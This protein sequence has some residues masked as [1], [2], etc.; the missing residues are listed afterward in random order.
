MSRRVDLERTDVDATFTR[1]PAPPTQEAAAEKIFR[2]IQRHNPKQQLKVD[3][4]GLHRGEAVRKVG[5]MLNIGRQ[6][7]AE[8]N[9]AVLQIVVGKGRNSTEGPQIK[10]EVAAFLDKQGDVRSEVDMWNDGVIVVHFL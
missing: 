1:E 10:P 2:E 6:L 5:S 9:E 3:L 7:R 4:H 8:G